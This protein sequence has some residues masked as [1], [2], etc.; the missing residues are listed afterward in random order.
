MKTIL[1]RHVLQLAL[2]AFAASLNMASAQENVSAPKSALERFA[3]QDYLFGT[4]GGLRT[5]LS[6]HGVDFEFF[7]I[8]SNPYNLDGGIKTGSAYE[9]AMLMLLDVD[10]D[11]LVGYHGGHMH[12]GGGSLH[13]EDHFSD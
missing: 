10:S 3:E 9:G 8:A 13:G 6:H 11:K 4:W 1:F 12:V 7:Y 2:V 5:D